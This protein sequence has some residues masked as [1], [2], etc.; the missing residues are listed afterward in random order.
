MAVLTIVQENSNPHYAIKWETLAFTLIPIGR[1]RRD[2]HYGRLWV[3]AMEAQS[4]LHNSIWNEWGKR[5]PHGG[6][7]LRCQYLR[8][9]R[10]KP[11]EML[12]EKGE[13]FRLLLL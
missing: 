5:Q 7:G 12:R 2:V 13:I 4:M 9:I 11:G 6:A 3:G 1:L 10:N 8:M